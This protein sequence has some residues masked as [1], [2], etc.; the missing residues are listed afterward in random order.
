[1]LFFRFQRLL[2][3][4]LLFSL[5]FSA[6]ADNEALNR[7]LSETDAP[8]EKT[9][10]SHAV[11]SPV[12]ENGGA[13][14]SVLDTPKETDARLSPV[15]HASDTAEQHVNALV[16]FLIKSAYVGSTDAQDCKTPYHNRS[17]TP[18]V[19]QKFYEWV[20]KAAE[21]G[22][23]KAQ[24]ILGIVQLYGGIGNMARNETEGLGWLTRAAQAGDTEAQLALYRVYSPYTSSCGFK[25]AKDEQKAFHWLT[26]AA[27]QNDP[28]AQFQLGIWQIMH[29]RDKS[30][31]DKAVKWFERAARQDHPATWYVFGLI[32]EYSDPPHPEAALL[33]FRKAAELGQADAQIR[34][35]IA[36]MNGKGVAQDRRQGFAWF[37]KAARQGS[38][39]GQY[40]LGSAY[41][42]G[43]GTPT[44]VHQA[45]YWFE[46]SAAGDHAY[47]QLALGSMYALGK[48]K[49][50]NEHEA[51]QWFDKSARQGTPEAQYLLGMLYLE[52]SGVPKN[53]KKAIAWL[54]KA[55]RQNYLLAQKMLAG[56]YLHAKN[57]TYPGPYSF[58]KNVPRA[59]YWLEKSAAKGDTDS[60]VMLAF[61]LMDG[62]HTRPD[63]K[64]A[65]KL[66]DKAIS[67]GN[68]RAV[69]L[70]GFYY[71]KFAPHQDKKRAVA[72]YRQAAAAGEPIAIE[73]L[74]QLGLPVTLKK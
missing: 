55:A 49:P 52:G 10:P 34:Y 5:V 29:Y 66:M 22:H 50:K 56:L 28:D 25:I 54:E 60:E 20:E 7:L 33:A 19:Q 71:E 42:N 3:V 69:V 53:D 12:T 36:L 65:K 62:Y 41:Y 68:I 58:D 64:R 21:N 2:L 46:K 8:A 47:G 74:R 31:I 24:T 18:E 14:K 35:G 15:Q 23:L 32:L 57:K 4:S 13:A 1:M 17:V 6:R 51:F 30:D 27:A 11:S 67:K 72:A 59:R 44:D 48:G 38:A 16:V 61:M 73:R 45:V 63:L 70:S 26:N 39:R 43:L 37:E 9:P 40:Y